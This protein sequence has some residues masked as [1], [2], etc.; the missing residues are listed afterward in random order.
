MANEELKVGY[1]VNWNSA[2]GTVTGTVKK[3]LTAPADIKTHHVAA[4]PDD[5]QWLVESAGSGQVAAHK[6]EAL[7]RSNRDKGMKGM[8]G[9]KGAK[10]K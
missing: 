5:P 2:Q 3:K 1:T 8:K 6:P 10:A 7:K 9:M 4:S